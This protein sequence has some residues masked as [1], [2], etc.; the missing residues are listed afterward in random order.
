AKAAK[1][2][3][4]P[5]TNYNVNTPANSL[6]YELSSVIVHKGKIDSGHYVSYSRE[7]N[8]WF[9]FDDSK[10]VLAN[11]AELLLKATKA[12]LRVVLQRRTSCSREWLRAS[13]IIAF[14]A[15]ESG[16]TFNHGHTHLIIVTEQQHALQLE[17][18]SEYHDTIAT[19]AC[20]LS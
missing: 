19:G 13:G 6:T 5:N 10:V 4:T 7:G 1:A 11:E 14:L 20:I 8:D 17:T 15:P 2:S 12:T 9:A 16:V 18:N 3:G